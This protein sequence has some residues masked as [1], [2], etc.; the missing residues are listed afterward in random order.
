MAMN[1]TPD[2]HRFDRRFFLFTAAGFILIVLAGFAQTYYLK[3]V[4]GS[5]QLRTLTHLHGLVMSA[6]V[7]F[8]AVQVFWVRQRA[9]KRHMQMGM[10][11][12]ALAALVV[13][14]GIAVAIE[15]AR[16]GSATA[17]PDIPPLPFLIVPLGDIVIF[18]LLFGAAVYWRKNAANHK[19]L[20]LL[21]VLNF[22]PPAVARIPIPALQSL[23]PLWFFGLPDLLAIT[24]VAYDTWKNGRLNRVF[25]V[26]ATL[27]ILS[28]PI[29]IM[30]SGT[31][32]WLRF[33]AW[34]TG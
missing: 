34:L 7:V 16:L 33:A 32:T 3:S 22:L 24:F 23:G 31:D 5:P 8:F 29:R 27:L 26:G 28:H 4:F 30:V 10:A 17:P 25:A 15:S 9:V 19:R 6:W 18:A 13:V 2:R 1:L 14:T 21:T 12:V 20:M 11:G